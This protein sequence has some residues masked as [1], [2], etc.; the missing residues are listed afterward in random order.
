MSCVWHIWRWPRVCVALIAGHKKNSEKS[1]SSAVT[2]TNA[3]S[4]HRTKRFLSDWS[5]V[6]VYVNVG[7]RTRFL[8]AV[9][10]FATQE[11]EA[12]KARVREMEE[13]AEKLKE[14][15]N[16]VE[17]QMNLSPPPGELI[18]FIITHTHTPPPYRS[19]WL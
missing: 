17:K 15:Q 1:K 13:E 5:V 12:I 6:A 11:L 10:L 14:L 9:S 8:I 4:P 3:Q 19:D 7:G 2:N 18:Y 16:E